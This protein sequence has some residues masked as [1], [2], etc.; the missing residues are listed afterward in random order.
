MRQMLSFLSHARVDAQYKIQMKRRLLNREGA[1]AL[2]KLNKIED[3]HAALEKSCSATAAAA[4]AAT[5]AEGSGSV[6][7]SSLGSRAYHTKI[8]HA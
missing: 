1:Q 5:A 8:R 3:Q 7:S 4:A 2:E 6:A